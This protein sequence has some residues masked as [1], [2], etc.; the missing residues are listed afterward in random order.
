ML[1]AVQ[2]DL[3]LCLHWF[4]SQTILSCQYLI[5]GE[6]GVQEVEEVS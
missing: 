6:T 3:S 4:N 1:G 2:T 5:G